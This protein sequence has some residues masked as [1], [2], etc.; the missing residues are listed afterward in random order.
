[1]GKGEMLVTSNFPFSR[2]VFKRL[3]QQTLKNQGFFGKGLIELNLVFSRF[4]ND[5]RC[6]KFRLV[7]VCK[8]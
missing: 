4:D 2:S 6:P 8:I 7:T 5:R 3:V 1:M